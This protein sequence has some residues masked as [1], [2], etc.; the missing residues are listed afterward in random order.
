MPDITRQAR[1]QA[2]SS[3]YDK[4]HH[5]GR[6]RLT[7][8]RDLYLRYVASCVDCGATVQVDAPIVGY[9]DGMPDITGDAVRT[10]CPTWG[11][12]G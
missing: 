12:E 5:V 4:G 1:E 8:D 10:V 7:E 11:Q 9:A 3:A 6:F 2:R